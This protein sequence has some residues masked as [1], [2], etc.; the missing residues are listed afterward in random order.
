MKPTKKTKPDAKTVEQDYYENG[1]ESTF[2]AP[3]EEMLKRIQPARR[4]E[5]NDSR[6]K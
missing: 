5:E 4:P 6:K 3:T 2:D 1:L